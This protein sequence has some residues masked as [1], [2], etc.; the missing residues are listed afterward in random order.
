MLKIARNR[1]P[2]CGLEIE[3]GRRARRALIRT[4]EHTR[5][6]IW[7]ARETNKL[8]YRLGILVRV[9]PA[10]PRD[11]AEADRIKGIVYLVHGSEAELRERIMPG[12]ARKR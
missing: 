6:H 3:G 12:S 5:C 8:S 4:G 11:P 2:P 1:R 7:S 10:Q 9:L